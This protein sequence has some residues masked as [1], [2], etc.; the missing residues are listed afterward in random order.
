MKFTPT[1]L[2]GVYSV[3]LAVHGDNRGWF[4]ETYN[5][6]AFARAGLNY[7]FVQDNH[8]YSALKGTLRGLHLQKP[9]YAQA[10]LVRCARGAVLDVVVD[11]RKD[12]PTYKQWVGVELSE[13]NHKSLMIPRGFAHGF[14]TL[15][16]DTE[17]CY[18]VDNPYDKASEAGILF[19]DP[20]IGV[21][22]GVQNPV[23]SE[24]DRNAPPLKDANL[25]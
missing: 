3:E 1:K 4:S 12:S 25:V 6:E 15:R 18:K 19:N 17:V 11:L 5:R 2:S 23:L 13:E 24:K 16:P 10:K 8:S 14:V 7:E 9:P 21:D 22:W 20:D